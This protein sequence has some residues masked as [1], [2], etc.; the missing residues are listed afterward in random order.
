M[1]KYLLSYNKGN[2]DKYMETANHY[3]KKQNELKDAILSHLR[4]I[5]YMSRMY[6]DK[7]TPVKVFGLAVNE[8][9]R[10][11]DCG[12]M[13]FLL[14]FPQCCQNVRNVCQGILKWTESDEEYASF[15]A[16]DIIEMEKLRKEKLAR[17]R[18][19]QHKHFVT[20][21]KLK[22]IRREVKEL[23]TELDKLTSREKENLKVIKQLEGEINMMSL[24]IEMLEDQ[25]DVIK[26]VQQS[27]RQSD[28][29]K[30]LHK[31]ASD[32]SELR[33][34]IPSTK[35]EIDGVKNKIAF[36]I[37]KRQLYESKTKEMKRL[38]HDV[39]YTK[40]AAIV[41]ETEM[42]RISNCLEILKYIHL[43][44]T[45]PASTRN[46][47]YNIPHREKIMQDKAKATQG[48]ILKRAPKVHTEC[49]KG[50][51]ICGVH[52]LILNQ[53]LKT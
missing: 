16:C 10:R 24:D 9:A 11:C 3:E 45:C 42:D 30:Q 44:K 48:R 37:D 8:I 31:I 19:E 40:M 22:Q 43:Q 46:I 52:C 21:H 36:I 38:K 29:P 27:D 51:I 32:I 2:T 35:K 1:E 26:E 50:T 5:T 17:M 53:K 25:R 14:V 47:F 7:G 15:I 6:Y 49:E 12:D 34:R 20:D 28:H 13:P 33:Y 4:N 41:S 23:E 18:E 39:T